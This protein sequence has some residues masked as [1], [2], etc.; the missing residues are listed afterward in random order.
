ML[1]AP[2]MRDLVVVGMI[3]GYVVAT[4]NLIIGLVIAMLLRFLE[5]RYDM[6]HTS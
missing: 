1:P 2:N 3:T 4:G 6:P 5:S